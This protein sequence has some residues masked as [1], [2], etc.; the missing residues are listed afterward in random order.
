[1]ATIHG[2]YVLDNV[3]SVRLTP[4]GIHSGM[5]ITIQNVSSS[6]YVYIGGEGVTTSDYGYRISPGH[7]ISW[8]LPEKDQLYAI[9]SAPEMK[10]AVLRTSLE[11]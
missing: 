9:S 11:K 1:M 2:I 5:D 4:L 3:S 10:I 6:G 8:E 7:S